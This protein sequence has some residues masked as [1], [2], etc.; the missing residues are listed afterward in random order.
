MLA[1]NLELSSWPEAVREL[2]AAAAAAP[3]N[4]VLHY[5]L[6]LVYE[7]R[8]DLSAALAAFER[9]QA[10]NPRH[11]AARGQVRA[12]DRVADLRRRLGAAR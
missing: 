3:D 6:G 8:G 9:S 5:N 2:E 10:I 4:D 1:L 12:A 11:L 7:R